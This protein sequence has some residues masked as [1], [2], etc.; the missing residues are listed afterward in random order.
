MN[1]DLLVTVILNFRFIAKRARL[2]L[3]EGRRIEIMEPFTSKVVS[4]LGY[5]GVNYE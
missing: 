1:T 3:I 2:A 4:I 5:F